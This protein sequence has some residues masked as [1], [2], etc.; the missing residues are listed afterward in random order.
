MQRLVVALGLL[1]SLAT[2]AEDWPQFRGPNRDSVWPETGILQTFPAEGLQV[3]WRTPVGAGNSSPVVARGRVYVTDSQAEKPKMW[4]RVHCFDEKTGKL[5]W[6]Y[7]YEVDWHPGFDPKNPSGTC[8]TPIVEGRLVFTLGAM[9][10]LLA[11]DTR[12]STLGWKRLLNQEYDLE[13]F[14]ELTV[15]PLI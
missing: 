4:E 8:P 7:R 2:S 5:I 11:L 9:G 14:P 12:K 6:T 13:K 10:H 3:R 1:L 15:R